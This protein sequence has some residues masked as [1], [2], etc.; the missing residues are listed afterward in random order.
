[1]SFFPP[2]SLPPTH[3]CKHVRTFTHGAHIREPHP[4]PPPS[5]VAAAAAAA[6]HAEKKGK[7]KSGRRRDS[8]TIA[9]L[10]LGLVPD[11]PPPPQ[12]G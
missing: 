4:P 1:M 8:P 6:A 11:R 2:P 10:K 9:S 7:E 3:A 5:S 12:I